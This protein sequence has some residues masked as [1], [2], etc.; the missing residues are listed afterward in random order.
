MQRALTADQVKHDMHRVEPLGYNCRQAS[1]N[2]SAAVVC[3]SDFRRKP[4]AV[5]QA[6]TATAN[7]PLF[8]HCST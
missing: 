5:S 1:K 7:E 8:D 3:P 2:V 6:A 4:I